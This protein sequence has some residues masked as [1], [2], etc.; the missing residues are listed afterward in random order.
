LLLWLDPLA[1]FSSVFSIRVA[2]SFA[3]GVLAGLG[4]GIL[5]ALSL[6]SGALWCTKLC[7]LGG[8]QELLDSAGSRLRGKGKSEPSAPR[9]G[10]GFAARRAFL[11][12]A[13]GIGLGLLARKVGA[14][15][16]EEAPLRPPGAVAE[17]IFAG[18]CTRCGNCVRACPSRVIHPDT[19]QAGL[20]GLL[21]PVLQY[22]RDYCREDCRACTDVCPSGAIQK[23]DLEQK[24]RY[25][26]GE[27]L[28]DGSIC[29]VTSGQKDCDACVRSCPFEA[30]E[31]K[32]DEEQYV[33]YPLVDA[34]KCNGCGACEVAC[35]TLDVKAISVWKA[36]SEKPEVE[37]NTRHTEKSTEPH[38]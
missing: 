24:R 15:R 8:A 25:V 14:A 10:R 37:R 26:I 4:F 27:A 19:G 33:A 11:L 31:M 29:L 16:G 9:Q 30:I 36:E 38:T 17:G 32:W 28:V 21:A 5:I 2:S 13:A 23:L 34:A 6:T 22:R 3:S 12:G 1:L 20:A 18:L 7:P 35:P